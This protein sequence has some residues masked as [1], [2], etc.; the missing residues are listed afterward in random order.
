MLHDFGDGVL[1][2]KSPGKK[3]VSYKRRKLVGGK[4]TRKE[5]FLHAGVCNIILPAGVGDEKRFLER[6]LAMTDSCPF[7]HG[8]EKGWTIRIMGKKCIFV[9][10]FTSMTTLHDCLFCKPLVED[11]GARDTKKYI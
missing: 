4:D 9:T 3:K 10:L 1:S 6:P 2:G 5:V 7:R 8:K 11:K